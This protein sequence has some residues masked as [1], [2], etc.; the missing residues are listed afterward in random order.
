MIF[1]EEKSPRLL[2]VSSCLW[3][4]NVLKLSKLL[5]GSEI[6][7]CLLGLL[8]GID[9]R[10]VRGTCPPLFKVMMHFVQFCEVKS[11]VFCKRSPK[12]FHNYDAYTRLLS[13]PVHVKLFYRIVSYRID[14]T[15]VNY[16]GY[17]SCSN[18]CLT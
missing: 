9:H 2:C 7:L 5:L 18:Q 10:V 1:V 11:S 17:V 12:F 8:M 13:F 6:L 14:S 4:K 16:S 3:S 15:C